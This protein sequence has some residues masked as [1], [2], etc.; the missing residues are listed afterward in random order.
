M[1]ENK[2][3]R[4]WESQKANAEKEIEKLEALSRKL[5]PLTPMQRM[6]QHLFMPEDMWEITA[7]IKKARKAVGQC[8]Q[9]LAAFA[10]KEKT[11]PI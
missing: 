1:D 6:E 5:K 8:E 7:R 10:A 3:R 4:A 2:K 9:M 11:E